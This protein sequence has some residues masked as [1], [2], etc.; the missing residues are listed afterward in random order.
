MHSK[1]GTS[2]RL[3][4]DIYGLIY[5]NFPFSLYRRYIPPRKDNLDDEN[6][7]PGPRSNKFP[8]Y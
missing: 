8:C 1:V 3:D 6:G 2:V 7:L 5:G 4:R